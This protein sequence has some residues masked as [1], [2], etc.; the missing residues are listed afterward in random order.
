MMQYY[1][2]SPTALSRI[3]LLHSVLTPLSP[4]CPILPNFEL[5]YSSLVEAHTWNQCCWEYGLKEFKLGL[6]LQW[7][8]S[9]SD[10]LIHASGRPNYLAHRV[11]I[12]VWVPDSEC[13]I[14]KYKSK[15][16]CIYPANIL[17]IWWRW[18]W[19]INSTLPDKNLFRTSLRH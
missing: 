3:T 15:F 7:T 13:L 17:N 14:K 8:E 6:S 2:H 12:W 1:H 4:T 16:L 10:S 5:K 9:L 18:T 19:R 11:V